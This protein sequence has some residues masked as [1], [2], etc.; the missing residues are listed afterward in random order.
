MLTVMNW[1]CY[2][3]ASYSFYMIL[4]LN[5]IV[6]IYVCIYVCLHCRHMHNSGSDRLLW[7]LAKKTDVVNIA[8]QINVYSVLTDY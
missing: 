6:S 8:I 7:L 5:K 2:V 1:S 4:V 3:H